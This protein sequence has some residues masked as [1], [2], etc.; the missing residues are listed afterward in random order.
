MATIELGGHLR[1]A[2]DG[3]ECSNLYLDGDALMEAIDL[4]LVG[5]VL[6]KGHNWIGD[7]VFPPEDPDTPVGGGNRI[8]LQADYGRVRITIEQLGTPE[9]EAKQQEISRLRAALASAGD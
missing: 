9:E 4:P 8:D 6:A 1:K 7:F 5:V 2:G 3:Y